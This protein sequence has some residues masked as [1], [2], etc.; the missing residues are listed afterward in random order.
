[1]GDRRAVRV[2]TKAEASLSKAGCGYWD[3]GGGK[4]RNF[5]TPRT[6]RFVD[7]SHV[8]V[9]HVKLLAALSFDC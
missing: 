8:A 7:F 2:R 3:E 4:V 1:M 6:Q 9:C 5:P